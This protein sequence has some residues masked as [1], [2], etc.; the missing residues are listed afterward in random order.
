MPYFP[1]APTPAQILIPTFGRRSLA[2][3]AG[4]RKNAT[5]S[6]TSAYAQG[7]GVARM[8]RSGMRES[9]IALRSIRAT[10]AVSLASDAGP[11]ALPS[12]APGERDSL[13]LHR[14]VVSLEHF[15]GRVFAV[16]PEA[17]IEAAASQ[18]Q[19]FQ[20]HIRQPVR[21]RGIDIDLAA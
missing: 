2:S 18:P 12:Q 17:D 1:E 16:P 11:H 7:V 21:Q 8:E 6:R 13:A 3:S 14:V 9:R 4:G 15:E 20:R 10:L 19:I 5:R